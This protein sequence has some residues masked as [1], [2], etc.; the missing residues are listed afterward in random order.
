MVL[1]VGAGTAALAALLWIVRST[2]LQH[3]ALF[4]TLL[5]AFIGAVLCLPGEAP[6]W[7]YALLVWALG[8]A[9]ALLGWRRKIEPWWLGI[10]LGSVGAVVGPAVGIDEYPW[11]LAVG[12]ATSIFLMVVSVPTGQVPLLAVGTMGTFGYVTWA[13][14]RYFGETLSVPLTL[15]VVGGVFLGLA[16]VAGRLTQVTRGRR[17]RPRAGAASG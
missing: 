3:G 16:V 1:L 13:V 7:V 10:A 15:V 12:L 4:A 11:L 14:F 8:T 9:W 5:A 17:R 2:A 6:I